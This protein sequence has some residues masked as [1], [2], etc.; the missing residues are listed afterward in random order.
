MKLDL[1]KVGRLTALGALIV[2]VGA[3]DGFRYGPDAALAREQQAIAGGTYASAILFGNPNATDATVTVH[4]ANAQGAEAMNPVLTFTVPAGA[5]VQKYI[6]SLQGLA[7]GRYSVMIDSDQSIT[8][9]A[10]LSSVGPVVSTAYNGISQSDT[11]TTFNVP[12]VYKSYVGRYTT[13]AVIQNAGSAT[14]DVTISY[15]T[16]SGEVAKETKSIPANASITV[17]Q[18]LTAGLPAGFKGSALITSTQPVAEISLVSDGATA[19]ATVRGV[20]SGSAKVFAPALYNDYHNFR[21]AIQV[22]NVGSVAT[23]VK[24][25]YYNAATGAK[26]GEETTGAAIQPGASQQFLQFNAGT[27]VAQVPAGFNGAAVVTALDAGGSIAGV[28]NITETVQNYLESY[29]NV[30]IEAATTKV[31]CPSI[32]KN[33]HNYNTSLTVQNADS[34]ATNLTVSYVDAGGAVVASQTISGLAPGATYFT[35]TPTVGALANGFIGGAVVTSSGAKI[36]AVVNEQFGAGDQPGD[37]LFTY[38]CANI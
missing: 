17:D 27:T 16:A 24:L 20:K 36:V 7:D 22:Q 10:N 3:I 30:P 35:Y 34:A 9:V 33:Y 28:T 18:A 11:A 32:M 29:N 8:A 25:E 38:G 5:S 26:V 4:F 12:I 21:T 37:Q 14:A 15:R 31:N 1:R 13:A 23:N 2:S 6:P 19:L